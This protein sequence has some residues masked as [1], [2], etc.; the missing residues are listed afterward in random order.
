[1]S[2]S[3]RMYAW[4]G[5][6]INGN[7]IN[8]R[9]EGRS[10]AFVRAELQRQGIR[11]ARV[12][13]A[14]RV[15]WRWPAGR[16]KADA[17]GFSRQLATLLR[18]GVPLLQAFEVMGRSGGDEHLGRLL[19]QLQQDV[20]AGLGLADALQRHPRWFDRLYC[21]PVRVGEQSGTL[22]RQLEQLA[23]LLER[24]RALQRR[25]RKAMLYPLLLLLTGLGVSALLLL[26]VVPRFQGLFASFDSA[27]PRSRSG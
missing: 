8:G 3:T 17:A 16:D 5:T 15:Q 25:V 21:N 24:R 6:T 22:D 1:M 4:E 26:E 10:Q 12:R 7:K 18:A 9:T 14:S 11:A 27:L 19:T 23:N 2:H 13:P 20:G